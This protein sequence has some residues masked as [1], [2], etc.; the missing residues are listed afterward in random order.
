MG[1]EGEIDETG[2]RASVLRGAD[3]D[4]LGKSQNAQPELMDKT[5]EA[6]IHSL[7]VYEIEQEMQDEELKTVQ[8]ALDRS[9]DK[10]QDLYDFAPTGYFTLS[11]QGLIIEVNLTGASLLGMPRL[12]LIGRGFKRLVA[13]DSLDQWNKHIIAVLGDKE[14]KSCDLTLKRENGSSFYVRLESIRTDTSAEQKA[15]NEETHVIS[16]VVSDITERK[17]LEEEI[18]TTVATLKEAQRLARIG[19]W[20]LDLITSRL[21]WS[22]EVY[23]IFE[24]EPGEFGGSHEAFLDLIHPE[25]RERV[26]RAYADSLAN[27]NPYEIV[28]RLLFPDGR[29]KYAHE[30]CEHSYDAAG[31]ALRSIGTV[32][33]ITELTQ[34]Q[35]RREKERAHLRTLLQTIPDLI[36]LKNPDGIYLN[37][38]ARFER[39]FGAKEAEIVGKTDYDFV[40]DDIADSFREHDRI[41][42]AAGKPSINEEWL[43]FAD[44]GH[45]ELVETIKTPMHDRDGSLIGV[46]GVARNITAAR[47]AEDTARRLA[48]AIE[49]AAEAVIITDATGIIQYINHAQVVLSGYSLDEFLGQTPNVFKS[50][51]HG[52][53]SYKQLWETINAGNVWTGSFINKKKDGTEYHEDVSIS[54]V[55]DKSDN[56]TNFVVVEHDVTKQLAL[57]EQLFQAQKMETIGILAGG[58]SHDFNN[59]LQPIM[60]YTE[61]LM[62]GKKQG[63]PELDG[64]QK[65]YEA[66]KRGADLIKGLMIFSRRIQPEFGPVDLNHEIDQVRQLL[67]QTIPKTIRIDLRLSDDLNTVQADP[68]QIVQVLMNLGVN[69]RDAMPDGGELTIETANIQ[70]DKEYCNSH[71][72]AKPGSYV[73]LTVSDTGKG[74]D[75]ETLSHIFEPFFTTKEKGK[76]T[77]LGLATVYGIVKKHD[78]HIICYS[79]PGTGTTF[80][81]YFPS[82]KTEKDS[83]TPTDET[84]IPGG[85]ETVLIVDDEED[86]RI[87]GTTLLNRFGYQVITAGNGK[88]AV[89]VYLREKERIALIVLDLIMPVMDGRQC[90]AEILRINPKAKVIITSGYSEWGPADGVMAAGAK[91]FVEKPYNMRHLL[92]TAREVLDKN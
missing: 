71:L 89:E 30:R 68:S 40:D 61:L 49:Q 66:G 81:I 80:T 47:K 35:L 14:K 92:A 42:M 74:M 78:G 79:E 57:Q 39:F 26:D 13:P 58:I 83:D 51:F 25:D 56:L 32:Q 3:E 88:E 24:I 20:E 19:S 5:S 18:G 37:C 90:L 43:T 12:N 52:G 75:E 15:A 31:V 69:A 22:D 55:Y 54:P 4:Q 76:G 67:S 7:E 9:K 64:L 63:D 62:M 33:D 2:S 23:R 29:V 46:L 11:R 85:T 10:Y 28:H 48:T 16:M 73:L 50:D 21:F 86:L 1:N 38:N 53:N 8:S 87:L 6:I 77:G 36:W 72:E 60:G 65:I 70:L 44:D 17:K 27:K 45:R 34:A 84:A 41:A 59:L 91:G 82:I